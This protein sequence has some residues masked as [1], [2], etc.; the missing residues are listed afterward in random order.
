MATKELTLPADLAAKLDARVA[1][2]EAASA[3][4]V[5]RAA[6][7][8]LEAAEDARKIDAVRE[9]IARSLADPRPSIPSDIVFD[10]VDQLLDSLQKR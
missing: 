7:A 3:V 9:K 8:A 6:L 1:R 10:R 2:G 5:V 4:D